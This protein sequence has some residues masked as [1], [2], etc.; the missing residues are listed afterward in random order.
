L[1]KIMDVEIAALKSLIP[2]YIFAEEDIA[3]ERFIVETLKARNQTL[4]I[5]ES[6]TGGYIAHLLTTV[7]GS[8]QCYKGGIIAYSDS[9][10][11]NLLDVPKALLEESGAVSEAVVRK[12]AESVRQK[13]QTDFGVAVSGIA[14]PTGAVE[15]KP[16]G[17]VWIAVSDGNTTVAE[18]F[19]FS[20]D[21]IR[22]IQR[23]AMAALNLLRRTFL[24]V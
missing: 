1:K 8:S 24:F 19:H 18:C 4:A 5:A 15:G 13:L 21:R 14:G 12:M 20:N 11:T 7:N 10:K 16:V 23:S 9:A 6:C 22:N 17:T 2:E 3:F